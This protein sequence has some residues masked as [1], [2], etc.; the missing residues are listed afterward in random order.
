M[1][2]YGLYCLLLLVAMFVAGKIMAQTNEPGKVQF[3]IGPSA[4]FYSSSLDLSDNRFFRGLDLARS[5]QMG[6]AESW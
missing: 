4:N 2:K 3:L 1:K 5:N 6:G